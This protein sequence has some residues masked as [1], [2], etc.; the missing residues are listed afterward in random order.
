MNNT[1]YQRDAYVA[2]FAAIRALG[3]EHECVEP[4]PFNPGGTRDT[5]KGATLY[6]AIYEAITK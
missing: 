6:K 4:N 5:E 1:P 2:Y 3:I